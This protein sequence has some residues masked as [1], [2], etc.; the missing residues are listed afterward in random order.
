M[1]VLTGPCHGSWPVFL[2]ALLIGF[3]SM[4]FA[5]DEKADTADVSNDWI[6]VLRVEG[7]ST[8]YDSMA[9]T[10]EEQSW[11]PPPRN[12]YEPTLVKLRR[13]EVEP[14]S[15]KQKELEARVEFMFL[16]EEDEDRRILVELVARDEKRR[17]I[18]RSWELT[19][20]GRIG[21]EFVD[22]GRVRGRRSEMNSHRFEIPQ[23]IE[24]QIAG[25]DVSFRSLKPEDWY[26]LPL[27]PTDLEITMSRPDEAGRFRVSFGS[28]SWW[29]LP[30]EE[31]GVAVIV[32]TPDPEKDG[33]FVMHSTHVLDVPAIGARYEI[34]LQLALD[35][36]DRCN[37]EVT[38]LKE[39]EPG[40]TERRFLKG[41][42]ETGYGG[43][44]SSRSFPIIHVP[45]EGAAPWGK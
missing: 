6:I 22:F 37:F 10:G 27:R 32:H 31:T 29:K 26:H 38:F 35:V 39:L 23:E 36:I 11:F 21:P 4:A 24:R 17:Q 19:S 34:D 18:F 15:G 43:P 2:A 20:D 16:G 28:P 25:F 12:G 13:I 30:V 45:F 7:E 8:L 33:S 44:W 40:Y 3:S 42:T 41:I 1:P 9:R 5:Q 14:S